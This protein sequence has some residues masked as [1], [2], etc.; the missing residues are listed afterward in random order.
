[1]MQRFRSVGA[2]QR[3]VSIFSAIRNLFVPPS[4]KRS[5]LQIHLHRFQAMEQWQVVTRAAAIFDSRIC[6]ETMQLT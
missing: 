6:F 3:F 2:L 5:S 4:A 1:M